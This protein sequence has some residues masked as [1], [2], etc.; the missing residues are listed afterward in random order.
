MGEAMLKFLGYPEA[1]ARAMSARIDWTTTLILPIPQ[2]EG[3][4][5]QDVSVDGVQG[6][7]LTRGRQQPVH[8]GVGQRRHAVRPAG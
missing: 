6:T 7:F 1:E 5:H 8:A 3:I 2:G 4:T